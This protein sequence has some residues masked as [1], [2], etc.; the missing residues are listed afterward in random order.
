MLSHAVAGR[1]KHGP[2]DSMGGDIWK[3][4]PGFSWT[5]AYDHFALVDFNLYASTIINWNSFSELCES[6]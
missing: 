5:M 4:A 1:T 2:C 3:F 6:F